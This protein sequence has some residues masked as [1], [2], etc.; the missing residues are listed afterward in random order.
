MLTSFSPHCSRTS[1]DGIS[2][3]V[4]YITLPTEYLRGRMGQAFYRTMNIPDLVARNRSEYVNLAIRL[5]EDKEYYTNLRALLHERASL[6]WEDMEIPF[7]W[8]SFFS[9]AVGIP[10]L[11]WAEFISESGRDLSRE[12]D[13]LRQRSMNRNHFSSKYGDE[14]WILEEVR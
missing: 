3:T 9:T 13:L 1:A 4:P 2:V 11:P 10:P 12:T 14:R 7:R 8:A 6:I 5:A